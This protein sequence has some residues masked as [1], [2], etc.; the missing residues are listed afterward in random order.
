MVPSLP[1]GGAG[2]GA[3]ADRGHKQVCGCHLD[4]CGWQGKPPEKTPRKSLKQTY[5]LYCPHYDLHWLGR[6]CKGCLYMFTVVAMIP[7]FLRRDAFV[8]YS[9]FSLRS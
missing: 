8:I 6:G 5:L 2:G 7:R 1:P 3:L 4:G 9:A